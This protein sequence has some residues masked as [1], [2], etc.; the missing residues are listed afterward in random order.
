MSVCYAGDRLLQGINLADMLMKSVEK[1]A[2][3]NSQVALWF[4]QNW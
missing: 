1:A 2:V 4:Y 3:S